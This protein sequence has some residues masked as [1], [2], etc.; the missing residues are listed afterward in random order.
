MLY[1]GVN[2]SSDCDINFAPAK[3]SDSTVYRVQ[4]SK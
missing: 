4:M 2:M 1:Y 3:T